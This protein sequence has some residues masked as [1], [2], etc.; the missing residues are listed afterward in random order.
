MHVHQKLFSNFV[1]IKKDANF[2]PNNIR[3][4]YKKINNEKTLRNNKSSFFNF[5]VKIVFYRKNLISFSKNSVQY[6]S[7]FFSLASIKKQ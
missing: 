6:I 1:K 3:N 5:S 4:M 7:G 2:T